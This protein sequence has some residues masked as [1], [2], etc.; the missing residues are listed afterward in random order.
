M[1]YE[2]FLS[3]NDGMPPLWPR[4]PR[5]PEDEHVLTEVMADLTQAVGPEYPTLLRNLRVVDLCG[6]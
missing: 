1:E 3:Q 2:S 4:A 6:C 5:W